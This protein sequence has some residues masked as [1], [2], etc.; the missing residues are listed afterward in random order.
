MC[1]TGIRRASANGSR[2]WRTPSPGRERSPSLG[3]PL[4]LIHGPCSALSVLAIGPSR[5]W[6][7]RFLRPIPLCRCWNTAS[8]SRAA[9]RPT[10][11]EP[12]SAG[13]LS[14]RPR[15][16]EHSWLR[17]DP[18]PRVQRQRL[19][20]QAI[21]GL[22]SRPVTYFEVC[23]IMGETACR[24]HQ[25]IVTARSRAALVSGV[26][27]RGVLQAERGGLIQSGSKEA[28]SLE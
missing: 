15:S 27:F 24:F 19:P 20:N 13:L 3:I 26:S 4:P 11:A 5:L 23:G 1:W 17:L 12:S 16:F 28:S 6:P 22:V 10:C 7:L 9:L 18:A 2:R 21:G 25:P 8:W 14:L